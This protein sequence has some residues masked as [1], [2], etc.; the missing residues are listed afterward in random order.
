MGQVTYSDGST[1]SAL[2]N[3]LINE[4][5]CLQ[6]QNIIHNVQDLPALQTKAVKPFWRP[7]FAKEEKYLLI[8][9]ASID[10]Y[11]ELFDGT[12]DIQEKRYWAVKA[13]RCYNQNF[14]M[15]GKERIASVEMQQRYRE[16]TDFLLA[17]PP[18]P[19]YEEYHLLCADIY[20]L[21]SDFKRA[22]NMYN[23]VIGGKFDHIVEQGRQWCDANN[24][25]LMAIKEKSQLD[26]VGK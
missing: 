23:L 5:R 7:W 6:C 20:R 24:A 15:Y 17:H 21:R 12:H 9:R 26:V 19:K 2:S 25:S 22:N 14:L 3:I 8:P 11:F 13:Y 16:M 18:T 1:T 10:V 4:T